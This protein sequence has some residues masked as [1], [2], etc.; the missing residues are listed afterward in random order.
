M[1]LHDFLNSCTNIAESHIDSSSLNALLGRLFDSLEKRIEH[2]I[3]RHSKRTINNMP[4]DLR[5]KINL[6]DIVIF[7]DCV[8]A[9][10]W[11]V[12][13]SA[14]VD[15]AAG[16]EPNSLL[17]TISFDQSSICFFNAFADV[18]QFHARSHVGLSHLTNLTVAL[19]CFSE[20]I[21]L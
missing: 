20:V 21:N 18:D 3:K 8:I 1:R 13:S 17:D 2:G 14:I 11:S 7:E 12:V 15:A 6:H 16:R 10:I 9:R 4:I 5:A 19:C